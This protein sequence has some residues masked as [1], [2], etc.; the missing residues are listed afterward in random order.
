VKK[1]TEQLVGFGCTKSQGQRAGRTEGNQWEQRRGSRKQR[2]LQE[3]R[4]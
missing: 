2:G 4:V 3:N 1:S